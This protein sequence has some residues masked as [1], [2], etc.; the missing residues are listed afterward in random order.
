[1]EDDHLE[2]CLPGDTVSCS[3]AITLRRK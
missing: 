3:V 2:A 1:V